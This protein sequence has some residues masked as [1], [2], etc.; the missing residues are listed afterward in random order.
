[1]ARPLAS[2]DPVRVDV[3]H[4]H[5]TD[6]HG[7]LIFSPQGW[8]GHQ[9][10]ELHLPAIPLWC[11]VQESVVGVRG[12][13]LANASGVS[14]DGFNSAL[15]CRRA[16]LVKERV[17]ITEQISH[18]E[19]RRGQI[20]EHIAHIDALLGE[21]TGSRQAE[22]PEVALPAGSNPTADLVVE[23]LRE[24]GKPLHYRDIERELRARGKLQVDGKNPANTLLARFFNDSR[25]Y[26]PARGTYA[27]RNGRTEKSVGTKRKRSR[28]RS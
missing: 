18:L 2:K 14:T 5:P 4:S 17:P 20:D 25:L 15:Q 26:R 22:A 13:V 21:T 9:I 1:M 27:L 6:F 12:F 10:L 11:T 16:E 23:L 19:K 24:V 8:Y 7:T 3:L 28:G